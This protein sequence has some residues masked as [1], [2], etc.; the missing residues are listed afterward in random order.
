MLNKKNNVSRET[1]KK[2]LYMND[3]YLNILLKL[4]KKTAKKGNVPVAAIIV[5]K[6]KIIAKAYNKKNV[7]NIS[8][9]HAEMIAIKKACKKIKS[10]RLNECQMYVTL[11]PCKMC[12]AAIIES[13]ISQVI[14][15][16]NSTYKETE[17][18][19]SKKLII[20]KVKESE[21][22]NKI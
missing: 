12:M 1:L 15:L 18:N 2:G 21:E 3:K 8:I 16:T 22:Y 14:Y 13:R 6:D 9:D 4:S 19:N 11:E 17:L 10:W 20:E 5:K 7:S